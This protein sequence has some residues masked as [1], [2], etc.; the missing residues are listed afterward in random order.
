MRCICYDR[1]HPFRTAVWH[2]AYCR[3]YDH[4]RAGHPTRA[5]AWGWFADRVVRWA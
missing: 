4:D 2:L 1:Q 5:A 3:W